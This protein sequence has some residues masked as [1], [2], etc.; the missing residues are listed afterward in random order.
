INQLIGGE[1]VSLVVVAPLSVAAG[2]LWLRGQK[3]AASLALAPSLYA[4]YTY[5]TEIVGAQ[6]RR[7]P[8]NSEYFLPLSLGLLA[9][10]GA[11][12][13]AAI[14]TLKNGS[15]PVLGRRSRVAAAA[16][17]LAPNA[18][19]ALAWLAQLA[20]YTSGQRSQAYLDDPILWWLTK[21]L[22]LGIVIPV[23]VAAGIGMLR[24]RPL[25]TTMAAGLTGFLACLVGS[26]GAMGAVQ[27]AKHDPSASPAFV[28]VG[29]VIGLAAAGVSVHLLRATNTHD[30]YSPREIVAASQPVG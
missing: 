21:A 29:M 20:A 10:S 22:D 17:L 14:A 9:V 5:T 15:S 24:S 26:V 13:V 1:A 19:F 25:A 8:G 3:A 16:T 2:A 23:S 18:L 7:Y 12:A 27:M 11:I 6:Y 4:L 28:V 30:T